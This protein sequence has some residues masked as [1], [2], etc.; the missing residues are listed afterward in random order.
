M[1]EPS[2]TDKLWF[3]RRD[4]V[5]RG[6]FPAAWIRRYILLGRIRMTDELRLGAGDWRPAFRCDELIPEVLR[7]PLSEDNLARLRQARRV[8]DERGPDDR[9]AGGMASQAQLDRRTDGGPLR[10]VLLLA[11]VAVL[12]LLVVR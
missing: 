2:S 7:Q 12:A 1:S 3:T 9:R 11:L 4:G 5:V 10:G 6:P 8:A